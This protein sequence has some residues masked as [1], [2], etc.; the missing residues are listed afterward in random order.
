M[1]SRSP[2]C[3][4]STRMKPGSLLGCGAR[5]SPIGRWT[6]WVFCGT[7]PF[8]APLF[9]VVFDPISD[10]QRFLAACTKGHHEKGNSS[11]IFGNSGDVQ[12]RQYV[13]DF[14]NRGSAVARGSLLRLP[15]VLY[16]QA[17]SNGYSGPH[18]QIPA[19]LQRQRWRC[20]RR[21]TRPSASSRIKAASAAFFFL[22]NR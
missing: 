1:P 19:A 4:R 22:L 7:A 21:L 2:W 16:R 3:T 14:F 15:S 18:R 9:V 20:G 10:N 12:L 11:E 8:F 5:R 6:V 17:E 13:R